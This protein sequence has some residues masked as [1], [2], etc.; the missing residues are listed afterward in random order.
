MKH[1]FKETFLTFLHIALGIAAGFLLI[2]F[3]GQMLVL[4]FVENFFVDKAQWN[5]VRLI[6]LTVGF[7]AVSGIYLGIL[8][9]RRGYKTGEFAL[10]RDLPPLCAG[11]VVH[12]LL[13]LI[14]RWHMVTMG[15][16]Y[17]PAWLAANGGFPLDGAP[18]PPLTAFLFAL[19]FDC[20]YAAVMALGLFLGASKRAGERSSLHP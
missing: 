12:L 14:T 10:R 4:N 8:Y 6:S 5:V 17:F 2:Y 7:L 19:L 18:L 20:L 9:R 16:A 1:F 11:G 3:V 13:T 15:A